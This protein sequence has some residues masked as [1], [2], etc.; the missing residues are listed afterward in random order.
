MYSLFKMEH[1]TLTLHI[2]KMCFSKYL[3]LIVVLMDVLYTLIIIT[4]IYFVCKLVFT[5]DSGTKTRH[6]TQ[7]THITKMTHYTQ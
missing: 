7:V 5:G 2:P 3:L 6:N 1:V 4:I